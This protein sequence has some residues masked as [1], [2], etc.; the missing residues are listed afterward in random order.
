M[1]GCCSPIGHLGNLALDLVEAKRS[2]VRDAK[3]AD[4][5]L[6]HRLDEVEARSSIEYTSRESGPAIA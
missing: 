6:T 1:Q 2:R 3:S 5:R 4:G